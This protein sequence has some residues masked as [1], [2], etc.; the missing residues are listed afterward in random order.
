M[1]RPI[2]ERLNAAMEEPRDFS[3]REISEISRDAMEEIDRLKG[4]LNAHG[5]NPMSEYICKCGL[6]RSVPAGT[7]PF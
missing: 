6:R 7:P 3:M 1:E 2:E 5:I 4:L